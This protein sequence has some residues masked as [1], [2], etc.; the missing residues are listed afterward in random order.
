MNTYQAIVLFL[1]ILNNAIGSYC[2]V[3]K[4]FA[5]CD[6]IRSKCRA[7]DPYM[8]RVNAAGYFKKVVCVIMSLN[9]ILLIN[10]LLVLMERAYINPIGN[11]GVYIVST[12]LFFLFYMINAIY[13]YKGCYLKGV[14][15]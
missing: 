5:C 3:T 2:L 11:D 15:K 13:K 7:L 14:K 9:I 12:Q 10:L 6:Y 8:C 4:H 1:L